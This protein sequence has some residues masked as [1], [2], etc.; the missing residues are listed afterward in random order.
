LQIPANLIP[1]E[2]IQILYKARILK[3][4]NELGRRQPAKL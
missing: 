3:K 4:R 1:N 2:F